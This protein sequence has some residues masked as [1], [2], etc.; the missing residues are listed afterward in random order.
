LP[1]INGWTAAHFAAGEGQLE[2]LRLLLEKGADVNAST[3]DGMTV[4]DVAAQK[5]SAACAKYLLENGASGIQN[6]K[7]GTALLH[8]LIDPPSEM[9]FFQPASEKKNLK[10]NST[11]SVSLS[12]TAAMRL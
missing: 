2:C 11:C 7:A 3:A 4:I 1:T 5:G 10:K 8:Y 9:T 12:K 6:T